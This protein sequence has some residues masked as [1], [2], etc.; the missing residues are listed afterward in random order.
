MLACHSERSEAE[1]NAVEESLSKV[2]DAS[3]P[4]GMTGS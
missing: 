3:T 1:R 2:R 4:L